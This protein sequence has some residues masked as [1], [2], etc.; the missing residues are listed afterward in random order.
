[1]QNTAYIKEEEDKK[2]VFLHLMYIL[3]KKNMQKKK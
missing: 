1:M 3:K 2:K